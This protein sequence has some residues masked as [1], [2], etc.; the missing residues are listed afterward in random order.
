MLACVAALCAIAAS[1]A[2]AS[3]R[4]ESDHPIYGLK[5]FGSGAAGRCGAALVAASHITSRFNAPSRFSGGNSTT[6]ITT[7]D[8]AGHTYSCKWQS[9]SSRNQIINWACRS[10][11]VTV[12]WVWRRYRLQS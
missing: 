4:C 9:A 11:G 5:T 12:T 7:H 1:P 10:G 8:A 3:R 6:R 2:A